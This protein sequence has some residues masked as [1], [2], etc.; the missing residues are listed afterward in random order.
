M[1]TPA[2]QAFEVSIAGHVAEV[3]MTGPGPGHA[4]GPEFFEE[5]PRLFAHL[6]TDADV[7]A[8]VLRGGGGQFSYGLDLDRMAPLFAD[9]LDRD[10]IPARQ[11]F[12]RDLR[13]LQDS[14]SA[15]AECRTPVVAALTGWCIG[16]G[17]DLAAAADIRVATDDARFSIREARMA[18]VADIGSLQRL[19]GVIGD[20]H[21][22]QLALTGEDFDA[23]RAL[24]IGLVNDIAPSAEATVDQARGIARAI[25]ANS[26]LVTRGIKEVLE[27]ERAGRVA[28][29][30][31]YVGAWNAAF[32]G[33]RDLV[34][35]L[36][37]FSE[38]RSPIFRG[39]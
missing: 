12:L 22:R 14:I 4:M 32:L 37:A 25:A 7:R 18:I 38:R 8:I 20:G 34:E 11:K 19:A 36:A 3:T 17:V 9:L 24:R 5:L 29:G 2:W 28:D 31:R 26:P 23:A 1:A 35:A 27:V 15:V 33:S 10:D 16:G 21:L 6:D 39:E 13:V 30:L